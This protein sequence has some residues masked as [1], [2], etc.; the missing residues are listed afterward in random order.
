MERE[1]W[2]SR[3]QLRGYLFEIIIMELLRKNQFSDINIASEPADRVR[4]VRSGFI[5]IKGRGC[6]HQIDCPC[7]YNHLIPFSY[8]VRLLGE[9]KFYKSRL[10]KDLIREYIGVIKD[11]QENY[12]AADG[13]DL[14][15]YYPRKTEIGAYFSA[16]G[17]QE[18]AEKL[19]YVHGIKTISYKNN[20]LINR[21]KFLV[22][23]L[24]NNYISTRILKDHRWNDFKNSF[25]NAIRHGI[26][27]NS[28]YNPN[29]ADGYLEIINEITQSFLSIRS[30]F[31]ATT[32]TGVFLHFLG[33][34]EFPYRLFQET[35]E[36]RCRV[37]Y[38]YD[39]FRNRYFWMEITGD[40]QRRRFYFTPPESLDYAAVFGSEIVLN[41]KERL[42]RTL[43]V[44]IQL[45]GISR[46]LLLYLDQDWLD[47]I[48][49]ENHRLY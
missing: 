37:F 31:I 43:S 13:V 21:L 25:R 3:N 44:N 8:P 17:F 14:Q 41:E 45:N 34:S 40:E 32:T 48:R 12:F 39:D 9:V 36:G 47:A 18:E 1:F 49:K 2:Q 30:S 22:E 10:S 19:A 11:I 24:E 38:E 28:E 33:D 16:N 27:I 35:D 15:N 29:L 23:E 20:Y 26:D 6:W 7:D 46:S 4:E 42:F 5:E